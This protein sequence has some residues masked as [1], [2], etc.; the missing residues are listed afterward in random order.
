MWPAKPNNTPNPCDTWKI[1]PSGK[2]GHGS[3]N[4]K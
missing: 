4:C 1:N 3:A 2:R